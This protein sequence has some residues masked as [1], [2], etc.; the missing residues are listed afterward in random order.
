MGG[1]RPP[2]LSSASSLAAKPKRP[3][4]P[5]AATRLYTG[6]EVARFFEVDLK[7]IHH[8]AD[9]GKIPHHRTEGRHLRFR[10]NHVVQF[11]RQHGY[12]IPAELAS[13]RPVV[14]YAGR[15]ERDGEVVKK[16]AARFAV[17]RFPDG[18][19]A[20]AHLVAGEPDAVILASDDPTFGGR[21]ALAALRARPETSF[22]V[23]VLLDRG[24][25]KEEAAGPEPDLAIPAEEVL[26]LPVDLAR[27][28]GVT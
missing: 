19:L 23:F 27:L 28:L 17:E 7:T 14:F 21:L 2:A 12:P 24:G 20:L 18:A 6:Q 15:D 3:G 9:A 22:P 4:P 26:R 11:L 10:R 25:G 16:L 8:W 5:A 13:A 1:R